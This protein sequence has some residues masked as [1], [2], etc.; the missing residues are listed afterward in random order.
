MRFFRWLK[1]SHD[2]L[3]FIDK[4]DVFLTETVFFKENE[5]IHLAIV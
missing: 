4:F 5:L 2:I 3:C 1:L